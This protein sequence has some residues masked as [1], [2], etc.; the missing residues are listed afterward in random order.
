MIA[1]RASTGC[2]TA[3]ADAY[4]TTYTHCSL[5]VQLKLRHLHLY[6]FTLQSYYLHI[7]HKQSYRLL[8]NLFLVNLTLL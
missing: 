4:A 6:P 7:L 2:C 1:S 5:L 8:Q 3:I